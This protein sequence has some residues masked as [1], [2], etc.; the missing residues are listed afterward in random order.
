MVTYL[1]TV[2]VK[3]FEKFSLNFSISLFVIRVR[4]E[5]GTAARAYYVNLRQP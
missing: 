1:S 4:H 2:T 5:R 3:R